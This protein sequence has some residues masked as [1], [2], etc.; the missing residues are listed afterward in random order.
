MIL[1][2]ALIVFATGLVDSA[3]GGTISGT[4]RAQG[5]EESRSGGTD[6]GYASRR[7]KFVE[8]VN[9][10]RLQDF[11]V[12]IDQVVPGAG[13]SVVGNSL[14]G[15]TGSAIGA[16]LG[17]AA[18]GAVGNNLGDDDGGSHSGGHKHKNKHKN[19]HR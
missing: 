12:S 11:V 16:G 7:Y 8:K 3:F 10:E 13:G 5:A 2:F 19:K 14:G 1:R 17:G 6:D 15:S 18:G 4:V 9:Y